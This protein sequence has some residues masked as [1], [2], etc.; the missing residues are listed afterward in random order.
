[1]DYKDNKSKI[2]DLLDT[3]KIEG[4]KPVHVENMRELLVQRDRYLNMSNPINIVHD[5]PIKNNSR[6]V[7]I[8]YPGLPPHIKRR[9]TFE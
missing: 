3:M 8:P 6:K 7:V 9:S 4:R 2:Q 1:M 5:K